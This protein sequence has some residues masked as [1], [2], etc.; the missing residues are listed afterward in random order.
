MHVASSGGQLYNLCKLRHLVVKFV[1]NVSG[2]I[3]L[4]NLVQ[5]TESISG[6]VV[7]LAMFNHLLQN[8]LLL[9]IH[10]LHQRCKPQNCADSPQCSFPSMCHSFPPRHQYTFFLLLCSRRSR[11]CTLSSYSSRAPCS[12]HKLCC[13]RGLAK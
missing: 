7:P 10:K 13:H 9:H 4:P 5:V 3:L 8:L 1:T 11:F 12:L 6:S 2:V